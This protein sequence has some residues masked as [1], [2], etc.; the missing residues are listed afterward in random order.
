MPGPLQVARFGVGKGSAVALCLPITIAAVV[1]FY[2]IA[3][4]GAL[5]VPLFIGLGPRRSRPDCKIPAEV[6]ISAES[7]GRRGRVVAMKSVL[8]EAVAGY[9]SLEH[10]VISAPRASAGLVA[11]DDGR[12]AEAMD[13]G[14]PLDA[15]L[16]IG[17]DQPAERGGAHAPG[18]SGQDRVRGR[19]RLRHHDRRRV[20]WVTDLGWVMG[21]LSIVGTHANGAA[22]VLYEGSPTCRT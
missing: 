4:V 2:A 11:S 17:H 19:V 5:A 18:L 1:S 8:N 12:D 7:T 9:P 3:R 22:I 13:P 21:P 6:M 14:D 20:L 15:R 10:V 16:Y